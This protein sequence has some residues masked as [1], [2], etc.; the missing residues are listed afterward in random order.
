MP[1]KARAD[2]AAELSGR[3]RVSLRL[4]LIG[5]SACTVSL[6]VAACVLPTALLWRR[7]LASLTEVARGTTDEHLGTYRAAVVAGVAERLEALLRSPVMVAQLL[8][9]AVAPLP[10]LT[11][12]SWEL[13]ERMQEVFVPLASAEHWPY[14]WSMQVAWQDVRG[15]QHQFRR[16]FGAGTYG[17]WDPCNS[18]TM[19]FWRY[20]GTRPTKELATQMA[21]ATLDTR[22]WWLRPHDPALLRDNAA[23]CPPFWSVTPGE[24]KL[25]TVSYAFPADLYD[26]SSPTF[27]ISMSAFSVA[28]LNDYLGTIRHSPSGW[29]LL[30]E[31]P[32]HNIV[33]SSVAAYVPATNATMPAAESP[34]EAVRAAVRR[35]G[36]AGRPARMALPGDVLLDAVGLAV[37]GGGIDLRLFVVTPRSDF[38]GGIDSANAR[39]ARA[40]SA[41]L[42]WVVAA[43]GAI[44]VVALAASV[45]MAFRLTTPLERIKR[46]LEGVGHLDIDDDDGSA[47]AAGSKGSKGGRGW[48]SEG[49][50]AYSFISE[51][52]DLELETQRMGVAL[53]SFAKYVPRLV[54]QHLLRRR[55][56]AEVGVVR[57]QAT[58]FFLDIA[59]FTQLMDSRGPVEVI[60]VL[61]RMF[62]RFSRVLTSHSG[63]IDKYIGDS[64]MA[65]WGVPEETRDPVGSACAAVAEILAELADINAG[66]R[67]QYAGLAMRVRIGLHTGEVY[68]GNVGCSER[69]NYTV[70]GNTV[71]L[72]ARLE[73]LNKEFGTVT[74]VSDAVRSAAP[75]GFAWR[76]LG[77]VHIRGIAE[78]VRVHEFVGRT[79]ELSAEQRELVE[80]YAALDERLLAMGP[81]DDLPRQLFDEYIAANP[82]DE[83]PQ[84]ILE[85]AC[86]SHGHRHSAVPTVTAM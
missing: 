49:A 40:A 21:L 4:L 67:G 8:A 32:Q 62:E 77:F 25:V 16:V 65:F 63:V 33:A 60:E 17:V 53:A 45:L 2:S 61:R 38:V 72:A 13:E 43:E 1:R 50:G 78:P 28:G 48:R 20:N 59:D 84:R 46:R 27:P 74:L 80:A 36:E 47:A 15:C 37:P 35:W 66:L 51:V 76:C 44:L 83:V 18:T 64:I 54:V 12:A 19:H 9:Q 30:V 26:R 71:N 31:G 6:V 86:G 24:G 41:T 68:A 42:L 3:L 10:L 79:E 34:H 73:P 29:V 7:S 82:A 58:I 39:E 22:A 70:I 81:G 69:L 75:A 14:I 11:H 57:A 55:V 56:A 23:W 52:S 5:Y 85:Q